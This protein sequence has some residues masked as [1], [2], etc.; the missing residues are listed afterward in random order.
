MRSNGFTLIEILIVVV[1]L[2]IL[3]AIVIPQFTDATRDAKD[4]SVRAQLRIVRE[5]IELYRIKAGEDPDLEGEQWDDLVTNNYLHRAPV[6]PINGSTE[7]HDHPQAGVGWVWT[8]SGFN[9]VKQLYATDETSLA[10]FEE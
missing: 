3:A 10:L 1:I 6:N 7:V 9:N 5:Q 2:G 8:D 4:S